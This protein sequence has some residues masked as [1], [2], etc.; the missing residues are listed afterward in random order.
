MPSIN[1][2]VSFLSAVT[3]AAAWKSQGCYSSTG[4]LE[5]QGT[6]IYQSA[7]YC[8]DQ[9]KASAAMALTGGDECFCG[10]ELPP[11]S[12]KVEDS[13]CDTTCF[14]YPA[15]ICGGDGLFSAYTLT[16]SG[17]GVSGNSSAVAPSSV[18]SAG[19]TGSNTTS[20]PSI[21]ASSTQSAASYTGAA[22][23]QVPGLG[24]L[25]VAGIAAAL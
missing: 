20:S 9:C 11:A 1:T 18:G 2:L 15:D 7:G 14:G 13:R 10:N 8:A 17:G 12:S 16:N 22:S 3:A 6:Y 21:T 23:Q 5:S 19:S 4:S 25:I 24:A